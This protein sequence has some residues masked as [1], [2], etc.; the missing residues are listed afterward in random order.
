MKQDTPDTQDTS[1]SELNVRH[2]VTLLKTS[3]ESK[4]ETKN[5][6]GHI[7]ISHM[8]EPRVVDLLKQEILIQIL[9]HYR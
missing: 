8:M 9:E 1:S 4:M 6:T 3:S 5:N 2:Y 7:N